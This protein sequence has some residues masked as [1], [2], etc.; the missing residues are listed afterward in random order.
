[1]ASD[2]NGHGASLKRVSIAMIILPTVAI[3]LR[4]WSRSISP[5]NHRFRKKFWHDDWLAIIGWIFSVGMSSLHYANVNNGLGQHVQ[6]I[7]KDDMTAILKNTYSSYFVFDIGILFPKLSVLFFYA[8]LFEVKG[9]FHKICQWVAVA[10]MIVWLCYRIPVDALPCIPVRK[11]WEPFT[12]GSCLISKN[13]Q[14]IWIVHGTLDCVTDLLLLIMPL[15]SIWR[16]QMKTGKKLMVTFAFICGYANIATSIGRAAALAVSAHQKGMDWTYN[17][18]NVSLWF[19]IEPAIA[20]VSVCLPSWF[21]LFKRASRFGLAALFTTR[22]FSIPYSSQTSTNR[23]NYMIGSN[24]TQQEKASPFLATINEFQEPSSPKYAGF[25]NIVQS[26]SVMLT[27]P[28]N[29]HL[30]F[31]WDVGRAV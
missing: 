12:P 13:V 3:A 30:K 14:T 7:S 9:R 6:Y 5:P 15:P 20:V 16:L 22:D 2:T 26:D 18:G 19:I 21:C 31:P 1:M 27:E 11:L 17:A 4:V 23:G 24:A 10:L 8:R 25:S 28:G 29:V